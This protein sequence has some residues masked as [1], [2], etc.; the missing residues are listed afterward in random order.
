MPASTEEIEETKADNVKIE[1]LTNILEYEKNIV[2]CIK[3]E[4]VEVENSKRKVPKNI[5]NSEF[6]IIADYIVLATGSLPNIKAIEN[7]EKNEKGYIKVNEKYQTS[8][9]K[10]FAG[11][12]IIGTNST[13]AFAVSDGLKASKEIKE[14]LLK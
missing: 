12:D 1:Y 7:F 13:V 3:T 8:L 9:E 11:G 14:F 5:P 4:L 10:V 6:E 2:K